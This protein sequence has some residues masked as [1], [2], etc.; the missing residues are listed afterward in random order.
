[1]DGTVE[2]RPWDDIPGAG[3]ASADYLRAYA[4]TIASVWSANWVRYSSA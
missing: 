4:M 3:C 2:G 1:M